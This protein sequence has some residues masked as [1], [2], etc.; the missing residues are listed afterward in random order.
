[1]ADYVTKVMDKLTEGLG[2]SP[3]QTNTGYV[4]ILNDSN[5]FSKAVGILNT[6]V[7]L[8]LDYPINDMQVDDDGNTTYMTNSYSVIDSTSVINAIISIDSDYSRVEIDIE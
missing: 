5:L 6:L 4:Y 7:D 3:R 8:Y 2:K 1:M